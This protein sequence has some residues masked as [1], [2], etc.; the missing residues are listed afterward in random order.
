MIAQSVEEQSI[1][2][3]EIANT[4]LQLS[5]GI[6]IVNENV[7]QSSE[8][9]GQIAGDIAE[10]SQA[11]NDMSSSSSQLSLSAEKLSQMAGHLKEMMGRF[12]V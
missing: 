5:D 1:T 9:S 2:T 6:N 7:A 4:V 11:T 8:V 3:K 12:K 10:V